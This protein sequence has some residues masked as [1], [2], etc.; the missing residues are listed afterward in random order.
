MWLSDN[1]RL[2]YSAGSKAYI[3]D[4]LTK[5]VREVFDAG[6]ERIS[7]VGIAKD[8]RLLYFTIYQSESN[9]WLLDCSGG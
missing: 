7:S 3:A 4:T 6:E 1:R 8:G 5:R 9:I 2:V